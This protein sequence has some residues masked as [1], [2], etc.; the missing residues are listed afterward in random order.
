MLGDTFRGP[1]KGWTIYAMVFG[2]AITGFFIYS[3][4]Q[5]LAAE[6]VTAHLHWM[7]AVI[8]AGIGIVLMKIWFWLLMMRNS[9]LKALEK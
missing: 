8:L 2:L 9:I 1:M 3:F 5:F 6:T 7:L 4:M